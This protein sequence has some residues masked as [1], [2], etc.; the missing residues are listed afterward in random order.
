MSDVVLAGCP[1]CETWG[2]HEL[3][4]HPN[5]E[6]DGPNSAPSAALRCGLCG[7]RFDSTT[8]LDEDECERYIPDQ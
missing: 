5:A 8:D 2:P 1:H 3:L 4:G 7:E 6:I